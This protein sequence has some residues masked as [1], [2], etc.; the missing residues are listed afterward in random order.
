MPELP[1]VET[2][3]RGLRV[4][5]VRRAIVGVEV[6][7]ARTLGGLAPESF[8]ELMIG[9]TIT[10]VGRRGKFVVMGLD[11]GAAVTIHR[12]MT[13]NLLVVPPGVEPSPHT[14][15][16]FRLDDDREL[17]FVDIRKF[18]RVLYFPSAEALEEHLR[19]KSGPEPLDDLTPGRLEAL[20]HGRR[21]RLKAL[22][23][24]QRFLAGIGNLYADEILWRAE[25]HP[26]RVA[27]SLAAEEIERLA[28]AIP[29]VLQDA[30]E[31]RGT[32]FSDH[33]DAEGERGENQDYLHAYGREGL[34]C[35][36]CGTPISKYRLGQR[37]TH[38]C[39]TCQPLP[40]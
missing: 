6:G 8:A 28:E 30:I 13:G 9:R 40:G 20:L 32:S 11:D 38:I 4:L 7:W 35:R 27:D 2:T 31:R 34:P 29:A 23:L 3:A 19:L 25:L 16:A 15:L 17:R 10:D 5:I 22:L 39:R 18:G 26:E 37:G 14:R 24:D 21:G 12:R 33:R 36:R 1:E